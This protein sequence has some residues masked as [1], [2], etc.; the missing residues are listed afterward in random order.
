MTHGIGWIWKR[1]T[2]MFLAGV[3]ILLPL[4]VTVG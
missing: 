4:V 3:F 2:G 1:I